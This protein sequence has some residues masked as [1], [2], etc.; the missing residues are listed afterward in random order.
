MTQTDA[1]TRATDLNKSG[2]VFAALLLGLALALRL[3]W[4]LAV[5]HAIAFPDEKQYLNIAGNFLAGEG[6]TVT[7]DSS[8]DQM[9]HVH[10][11]MHR[12]PVYPLVLALLTK[13]G[14]GYEGIR[15]T[16]AA[17]GALAAVMVWLLARE[18]ASERAARIA[19]LLA[20]VDPFSVYFTGLFL[21]ETLFVLLFV[22]CWYYV[23]R[24]WR[25]AGS[26]EPASRWIASSLVAGLLGAAAALTRSEA[27]PVLALAPAAWLIVGPARAKGLLASCLILLAL[28][29][30]L[31]PWVAL[32]YRRTYREDTG[33]RIILATCNVGASLYE[34]VGPFATGGP[35]KQNTAWPEEA[36]LLAGDEAAFDRCLLDKSLAYMRHD[37]ARTL[38]LAGVKFLRTWN[39]FPN[40]E[41]ERTTRRMWISA[42]FMVPV[43]LAALLGLWALRRRR[44]LVWVLLP[45]VVWTLVHMVFVGS[46]RYRVPMMPLVFILSGAGA[47]WLWSLLRPRSL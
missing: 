4:V 42:G 9:L 5:P 15:A 40:F 39:L 19:G 2:Y 7:V 11:L 41:P 44:E 10:L 35:N 30:G 37:P 23:V 24:A 18:L 36:T 28:A 22:T 27:L 13:L 21:S 14:L 1:P 29:V 38:R 46:V 45:V 33:G 34:A 32:N 6:L 43:C 3:G 17:L 16:Q 12:V 26:S 25:E 8:T 31:S 47:A 20:A